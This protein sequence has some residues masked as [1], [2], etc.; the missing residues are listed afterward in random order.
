MKEHDSSF[1]S[2]ESQQFF[3]YHSSL[4]VAFIISVRHFLTAL[5]SSVL[6]SSALSQLPSLDKITNTTHVPTLKKHCK[7][8]RTHFYFS[9]GL[10]RCHLSLAQH[11][12][13]CPLEH[14]RYA[15]TSIYGIISYLPVASYAYKTAD[16]VA[17]ESKTSRSRKL[18]LLTSLIRYLADW[19]AIGSSV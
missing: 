3:L 5:D 1:G 17:T 2:Q 12:I 9:G 10:F 11:L 8:H 4:H 7:R 13:Y 18:A 19:I 15:T 14:M 6:L 16:A